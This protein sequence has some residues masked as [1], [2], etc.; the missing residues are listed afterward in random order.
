MKYDQLPESVRIP[1]V[2]RCVPTEY[3]ATVLPRSDRVESGDVMLAGLERIGKNTGLELTNGRRCNLHKGDLMAVVLG[4]RYA[5]RQFE[6]YATTDGD[7]CDLLSMGGLAGSVATK[8]V[9]IPDPTRLRVL[10]SICDSAGQ[11][12]NL[13]RFEPVCPVIMRDPP[14]IVVCGTSMDSGKTYTAMSIVVG[15]RKQG[16]QVA[17][18]KLTGTA[19]GRDLWSMQDAGANPALDFVDAGFAST[20]LAPLHEL[21]RAH[22]LLCAQAAARGADI[23]VMEIADGLLERETAALLQTCNF[24]RTVDAW[25]LAATEPLSAVGGLSLLT[26]WGITPIAISGVVTMSPLA[27]R[28]V[29]SAIPI[30]CIPAGALQAGLLPVRLDRQEAYATLGA[31]R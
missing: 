18:I 15:L 11:P 2:L 29:N 7:E 4:H 3:L 13:R 21:L 12:L 6:G 19:T 22:D 16:Y 26:L 5:T 27:M 31:K 24:T 9:G 30:P 8:H 25:V 10:G 1:Y 14:L 28:E 23:I 20:Y 17:S